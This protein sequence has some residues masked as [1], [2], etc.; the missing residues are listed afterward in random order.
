[1]L[2]KVGVHHE[3]RFVS[4]SRLQAWATIRSK[5]Q[6]LGMAGVYSPGVLSAALKHSS[7][8]HLAHAVN[9]K[10]SISLLLKFLEAIRE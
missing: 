1:M 9:N 5:M 8:L 7:A 10:L 2:S 4:F 3:M 6:V